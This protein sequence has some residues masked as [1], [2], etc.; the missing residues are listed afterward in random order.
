MC[1]CCVCVC[2]CVCVCPCPCERFSVCKQ[3]LATHVHILLLSMFH[4]HSNTHVITHTHTHTHPPTAVRT[5]VAVEHMVEVVETCI[6]V[7]FASIP[8]MVDPDKEWKSICSTMAIPEG[9]IEQFRS[10][11]IRKNLFLSLFGLSLSELSALEHPRLEVD[12]MVKMTQWSS[13]MKPE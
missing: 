10:E 6:D 12:L 3:C 11:C 4:A 9:I 5:I 13:R 2:V 1:V 8:D 7:R